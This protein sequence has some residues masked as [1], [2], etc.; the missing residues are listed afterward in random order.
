MNRLLPA[1]LMLALFVMFL[2]VISPAA[3]EPADGV[4]VFPISPS[5]PMPEELASVLQ[6]LKDAGG[7]SAGFSQTLK[8][9]DGSSQMYRGEVDVLPPG[10]FRW[11]YIEPYEQLFISD[12]FSI[13]HY[14][15]D[16]MQA[17]VLKEMNDVD[18]AVM[19]LLGG[20]LGVADVHLLQVQAADHRY[21]VRLAADTKVWI[22]VSHG[23]LDYIEGSDALGNINRISLSGMRLTPPDAG[24]FAF[25]APEGV[26]VVPLR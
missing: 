3:S 16:L 20:R 18:P 1:M 13:W 8:F 14:E 25:V 9:S 22:A 10:R 24:G 12:G 6:N 2:P 5:L 23:R 7:F 11:R 15:P 21:Y 4:E 26:D 17:T 19:Q